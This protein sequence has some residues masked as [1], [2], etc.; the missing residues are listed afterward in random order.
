MLNAV[1]AIATNG[2]LLQPY[3]TKEI[4]GADGKLIEQG[5]TNQIHRVISP[6]TA[7]QMVEMLIGVT[8]GGSGWNARVDGYRV[9][10]KTGTAQKA[11]KGKGYVKDKVVTTFIGFLPA[12]DPGVSIIV[13]VD[14]P[15]GGPLSSRVTAPIFQKIASETIAYLNQTDVFAQPALAE[16]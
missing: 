3:I 15:A 4:R 13:V 12:D 8:E 10:G 16:R 11:E 7:T 2:V 5:T 6:E 1:N 14:E 9:A